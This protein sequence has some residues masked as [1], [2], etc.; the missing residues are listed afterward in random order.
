VCDVEGVLLFKLEA[1]AA[2]ADQSPQES[3][4]QRELF[5]AADVSLPPDTAERRTI[6]NAPHQDVFPPEDLLLLATFG[7][8]KMRKFHIPCKGRKN[9]QT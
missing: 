1:L 9:V 2:T 5:R 3:L 7:Y 8:K 4:Q 6:T